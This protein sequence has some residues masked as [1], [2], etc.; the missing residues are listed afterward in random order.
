MFDRTTYCQLTDAATAVLDCEKPTSLAELLSIELKFTIDTLNNW[1]SN[2]IKPK[3]L[4]LGD[5][6]RKDFIEKNKLLPETTCCICGFPLD[7]NAPGEKQWLNFVAER[8]HL[9]LRNIYT[10]EDLKATGID[11]TKKYSKIFER[12][13][14]LFPEVEAALE[15][16]I[17]SDEFKSFMEEDLN[18]MHTHVEEVKE[19]VDNIPVKKIFFIK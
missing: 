4:E 9:F 17:E 11:T 3:V 7:I 18:N 15:D 6:K 19:Y 2:R 10:I 14:N 12:F 5:V 1:F 8:K 16:E 13:L